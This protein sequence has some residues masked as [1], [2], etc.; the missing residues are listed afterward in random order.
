MVMALRDMMHTPEGASATCRQGA[1]DAS[2]ERKTQR[3][4]A[5]EVTWNNSKRAD[6]SVTKVVQVARHGEQARGTTRQL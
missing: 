4:G 3:Q 6:A 1:V 5:H 2:S